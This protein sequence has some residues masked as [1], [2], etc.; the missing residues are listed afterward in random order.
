LSVIKLGDMFTTTTP[1]DLADS[2]A[3]FKLMPLLKIF[4]GFLTLMALASMVPGAAKLINLQS[5]MP[6][7]TEV[8]RSLE[9]GL[10]GTNSAHE[11]SSFR[12]QLMCSL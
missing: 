4:R 11:S 6:S 8:K 1:M 2:M 10:V 7:P 12:Y 3:K 5:T 9:L